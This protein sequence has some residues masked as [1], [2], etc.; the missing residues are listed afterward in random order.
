[1]TLLHP[2]RYLVG[3]GRAVAIALLLNGGAAIAEGRP[4]EPL[5]GNLSP[6]QVTLSQPDLPAL[7]TWDLYLPE[8]QIQP[9]ILIRL[10]DRR[11]YL[12][13]G[14]EVVAS[15]PVAIGHPDTPTP[16]GTYE[17]FQ[18]VVDPAWQSP[19]TGE[20]HPPGPNSALGVRW[21]GF[22]EMP[23]GVIG[24]HGTPTVSSIGQAAS[25]GCVRMHNAD[26]MALFDQVD[27][28][29]MVVVVP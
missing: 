21:I 4:V 5:P 16:T 22:A 9:R 28:G 27:V 25:N 15:Y 7:G 24:L 11:V 1:M 17:V 29:T 10:S 18:M 8:E 13:H 26:V 19:W 23:N 6:D 3:L 2:S 20:V 12:Y 14:D